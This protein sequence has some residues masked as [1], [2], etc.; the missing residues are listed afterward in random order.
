MKCKD[1]YALIQDL[2]DGRLSTR[3]TEPLER[4]RS[5]CARC[6]SELR[7]YQA[8]T[9]LM[10]DMRP[11]TP[12]RGFADR[13]IVGLKATGRIAE[14]A[15]VRRVGVRWLR[16]RS[17]VALASAMLCLVALSL[18][19]ATIQPLTGLAGKG[20]VVV[21]GALVAVQDWLASGN[22]ITRVVDNVE[23][24]LRTVKTVLHAGFSVV[25]TAGDVLMLPALFILLM[26][27]VG[28]AWYA[29]VNHRGSTGHASFSF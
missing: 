7:T 6:A 17:R 21:T 25:S 12:P 18:F 20:A 9:A 29:R 22:A 11:E 28:G 10:D 2:I 3:D 26:L 24:N 13:V 1:A 15:A 27:T 8:L 5:K 16:T 23:K 14:T 19:P 4:H